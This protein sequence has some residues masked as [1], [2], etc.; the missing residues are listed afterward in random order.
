MMTDHP[1][2]F[3]DAMLRSDYPTFVARVIG[4]LEP[5]NI[6]EENWHSSISRVGS[7]GCGWASA[8]G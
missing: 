3:F 7:S 1:Q 4:E 5:A 6:Y 2:A 8:G